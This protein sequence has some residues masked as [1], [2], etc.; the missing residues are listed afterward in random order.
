[1]RF[2][3]TQLP[4]IL[5]GMVEDQVVLIKQISHRIVPRFIDIVVDE[6]L[7]TSAKLKDATT[8]YRNKHFENRSYFSCF[9]ATMVSNFA[10]F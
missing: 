5:F 8:A 3:Y 1:M 10:Y 6:F 9:T 4:S 2:F 7:N